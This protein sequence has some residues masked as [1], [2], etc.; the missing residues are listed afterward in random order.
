M[1]NCSWSHSSSACTSIRSSPLAFIHLAKVRSTGSV[2]APSQSV[3]VP[4]LKDNVMA[5]IDSKATINYTVRTGP[6]TV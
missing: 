6:G 1:S 5:S 4:C 2:Q 3:R